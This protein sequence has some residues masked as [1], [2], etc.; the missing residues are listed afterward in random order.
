MSSILV[1]NPG[2]GSTKIAIFE[3]EK[4]ILKR[5]IVHPHDEISRFKDV[6]SQRLYREEAIR[7]ALREEGAD[8]KSLTAVVGRGGALKPLESGTYRVNRLLAEDIKA[9]RVQTE[10]AS[11]LGALIAY[12]LAEEIGV[13][14]FMVDP[15][16]VD[17]FV[18]E[19]RISGMPEL[20]RRSLDHPLNAK[21]VAR[22][23]AAELGKTYETSN[24]IVA[25]LGTGISIS[26]HMQGRMIDVNNAHDGGPFSTQRTG[27]LPV[28]QLVDLCYSGK[29]TR[30]EMFAKI[31]RQGGL[32]AYLGTDDLREVEHRIES[33]DEHAALILRAMAYQI[34]KEIG[35]C[36]A[37]LG[38]KI[39]AII[40]TGGIAHSERVV[41][42]VKER[43]AFLCKNIF[44]FPGE[45]EM[46]AMAAGALRVLRG[47]EQAKEYK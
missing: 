26:V 7:Q 19:A 13:P 8:L 20:V 41:G 6:L 5:T 28:T 2:G 17:E 38:G 1:I 12:E 29:Y 21:M 40:F 18:P 22:K 34:A 15:V 24:M 44:V 39:N 25:H 23:A 4:C 14:A 3:D 47:T 32:K 10:H 27:S 9:G 16:S 11:N 33:G 36:A 35:A 45:H 43:I 42:L 46:E 37:V 30:D 31:T